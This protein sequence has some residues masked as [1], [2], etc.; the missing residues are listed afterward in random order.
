MIDEI[1]M[2]LKKGAKSSKRKND[3][4]IASDSTLLLNFYKISTRSGRREHHQFFIRNV[5]SL[6]AMSTF[7]YL[8]ILP[9]R[10]EQFTKLFAKNS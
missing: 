7:G 9:H 1:K 8:V 5:H 4:A 3:K 6:L 2:R 10:K